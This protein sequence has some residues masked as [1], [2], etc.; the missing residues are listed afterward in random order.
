MQDWK[1]TLIGILAAG[2]QFG[3]AFAPPKYQ[4]AID[5]ASGILLGLLGYH[6]A[7]KG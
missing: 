1:T 5:A 7:D 6:A 3:R 2:A 4:P